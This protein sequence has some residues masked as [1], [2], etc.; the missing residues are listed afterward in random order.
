MKL[1]KLYRLAHSLYKHKIPF[2]PQ[3]ICRLQQLIFNCYVPYD[4]E[5]G[6][7]TQFS[8]G[9]IG[10]LIHSKAKIG[11]NCI[12]CQG[13]SIGGRSNQNILPV[14]G[15]RVYIGPGAKILGNVKIGDDA[16]IA[17][18]CVVIKDVPARTIVGGVPAK[19]IKLIKES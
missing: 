3:L 16:V 5:I 18:N 4:V 19:I 10:V 11:K 2:L 8:Y 13:I 7:G 1:I 15:D 9:G 14:I 6:E 12:I 17:P